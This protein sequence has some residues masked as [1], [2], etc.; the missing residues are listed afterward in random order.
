MVKLYTIFW[1]WVFV[2]FILRS[3][4]CAAQRHK[5]SNDSWTHDENVNISENEIDSN[6]QKKRF[7]LLFV[8]KATDLASLFLVIWLFSSLRWEAKTTSKAIWKTCQLKW[9]RKWEAFSE[10]TL[11]KIH[12]E[13]AAKML[14]SLGAANKT[15]FSRFLELRNNVEFH[16][17]FSFMHFFLNYRRLNKNL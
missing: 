3:D 4:F 9:E 7:S 6:M 12:S 1:L 17:S 10:K 8:V 13:W 2:E 16:W 15:F 11:E 14:F 5:S